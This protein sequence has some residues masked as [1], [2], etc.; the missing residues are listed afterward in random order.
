LIVV[1]TCTN[2]LVTLGKLCT[3][4]MPN[5][6]GKYVCIYHIICVRVFACIIYVMSL[7]TSYPILIVSSR[8]QS[9]VTQEDPFTLVKL[10]MEDETLPT[11]SFDQ[12]VDGSK[13][14]STLLFTDPAIVQHRVTLEG[15]RG[16][17]LANDLGCGAWDFLDGINLAW[18]I[19][20]KS[21]FLPYF[22]QRRVMFCNALMGIFGSVVNCGQLFKGFPTAIQMAFAT[23]KCISYQ[24]SIPSDKMDEGNQSVLYLMMDLI[25]EAFREGGTSSEEWTREA[26]FKVAQ[27]YITFFDWSLLC[28][29][30]D[31]ND[32]NGTKWKTMKTHMKKRGGLILWRMFAVIN[33][34]WYIIENH[35]ASDGKQ[36]QLLEAS[37]RTGE[38]SHGLSKNEVNEGL[39]N[40]L[41][42]IYTVPHPNYQEIWISSRTISYGRLLKFDESLARCLQPLVGMTIPDGNDTLVLNK[43][44]FH[45]FIKRAKLHGLSQE[46]VEVVY[47]ADRKLRIEKKNL[48]LDIEAEMQSSVQAVV[49][50]KESIKDIALILVNDL[51]KK[52][53]IEN[54]LN[55]EE[56]RNGVQE[57]AAAKEKKLAAKDQEINR[58]KEE[59]TQWK[60][61][62]KFWKDG[63]QEREEEMTQWK[64]KAKFWKDKADFPQNMFKWKEKELKERAMMFAEKELQE[65]ERK[66]KER[67]EKLERERKRKELS[68]PYGFACIGQGSYP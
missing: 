65:R 27:S 50:G 39:S 28:C 15:I 26:A 64:D 24:G 48:K 31:E 32:V 55:S 7:I 19:R 5:T 23:K 62:A 17:D 11:S 68:E 43:E 67:E 20:N 44:S 47:E 37:S 29:E 36:L 40:E 52:K 12:R 3:V 6:D 56:I 66:L 35:I 61:K 14:L 41:V 18:A 38:L 46:Q 63:V 4:G 2:A 34:G 42:E 60:D 33:S 25:Y 21:W 16:E 13:A 22:K 49:N 54:C 8:P 57:R 45:L 51:A 59:M 53:L 9:V 58:L 1:V 30:G 10:F